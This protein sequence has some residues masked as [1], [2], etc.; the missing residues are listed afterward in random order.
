MFPRPVGLKSGRRPVIRMKERRQPMFDVVGIGLN[1]IDYLVSLPRFPVPGRKAA[2]VRFRARGRRPGGNRPRGA[3]PLGVPVQICRECGRR[4]ARAAFVPAPFAGGDRPRPRPDGSRRRF[5][6]RGDPRG[7]RDGGADHPLGPGSADPGLAGRTAAGRN[8]ARRGRCFSTATTFPRRLPRQGP[9]GQRASPSFST[10]K[11]CRRERR[12]C[13][14]CAITSWPRGTSRGCCFPG[15][16]RRMAP[17][18]ILRR[19]CDPRPPR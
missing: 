12:N 16:R 13:C 9:H 3:V 8:P 18:E 19:L 1:A 14:P 2:D 17:V 5:P 4:R 10:R 7:G 6:I 11:R 15:S